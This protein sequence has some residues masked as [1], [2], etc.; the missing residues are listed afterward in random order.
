MLYNEDRQN[1]ANAKLD[2]CFENPKKIKM[3]KHS[4]LRNACHCYSRLSFK[5]PCNRHSVTDE[6][7]QE[8]VNYVKSLKGWWFNEKTRD[9]SFRTAVYEK[10]KAIYKREAPERHD[11][12][13]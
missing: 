6:D 8:A 12:Q 3:L 10:G 7:V 9:V 13:I 2:Q 5:W 4:I 11:Y 1:E